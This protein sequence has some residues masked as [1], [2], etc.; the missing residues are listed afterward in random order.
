MWYGGSTMAVA[1]GHYVH[2]HTTFCTV[3]Y[4]TKWYGHVHDHTTFFTAYYYTNL[5]ICSM[6]I[7]CC[8]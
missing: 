5:S 1:T 4:Y 6:C 8:S 2:D 3:Y 7:I